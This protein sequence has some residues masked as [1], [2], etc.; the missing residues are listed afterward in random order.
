MRQQ[1]T[2]QEFRLA[3]AHI[4]NH[5]RSEHHP[6]IEEHQDGADAPGHS[7]R[8]SKNGNTSVVGHEKSRERTLLAGQP[9]LSR[10]LFLRNTLGGVLHQMGERHECRF[11]FRIERDGEPAE[12]APGDC[13]RE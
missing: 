11:R 10:L 13:D 12:G 7:E 8:Q 2:Q 6:I 3:R 1:P 9:V 5:D 4:V